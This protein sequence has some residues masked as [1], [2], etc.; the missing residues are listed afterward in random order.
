MKK[1]YYEVLGVSKNATDDEIKSAFRKLAKKYHP[2]VSKEKDAA[3]KFKEVQEAYAVLSDQEKRKR[4]D[5]YGHAAFEQGTSGGY[6]FSDFDFSDI[7]GDLFGGGF[8]FSSF[9]GRGSKNTSHKG[10]DRLVKMNLTFEE[11]AF[12]C[13]KTLNLNI[14]SKCDECN[15]LGGKGE[16][17][18]SACGGSGTVTKE[19]STLFG[20]FMTRTTCSTC[21]GAGHTYDA[22]CSKCRGTGK[23]RENKELEVKIPAGVDSGNRLRLAGK[24][25]AG[26]NGG[27]N[28]DIYIE[29]NVSSHPLFQRD[30]ENIYLTLPITI[31]TAVLGAKVDVPTLYG[32]VKLTIPAGSKSGDKHRLKGKGLEDPNSSRKG[33]MYVILDIQ[34]P[35]KLSKDQKKLFEALKD[36]KLDDSIAFK[37]IQKYL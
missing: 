33:D 8:G 37:N 30:E 4:Y 32:P 20:T 29:F 15:G 11:A 36:T 6:D 27:A 5:Q 2:D 25:E 16:K 35:S 26:V 1:D 14:D 28:G 22:K 18:C 7:F 3:E 9:G 21:G 34:V 23:I 13:K 31:T 24:G 12:G 17:K 10:S 19:Q